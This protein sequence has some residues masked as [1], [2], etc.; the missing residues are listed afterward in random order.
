MVNRRQ[1][2]PRVIHVAAV[3]QAPGEIPPSAGVE[4]HSG[5]PG[6]TELQPGE[7]QNESGGIVYGRYYL[8]VDVSQWNTDLCSQAQDGQWYCLEGAY[9]PPPPTTTTGNGAQ[10]EPNTPPIAPIIPPEEPKAQVPAV[11][12]Q[13]A[14]AVPAGEPAQ[15]GSWIW[16]LLLALYLLSRKDK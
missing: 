16:L 4:V 5:I 6:W 7:W 14:Q 1:Q 13:P 12:T 8:V 11:V 3:G 9:S 10:P 2:R 15:S